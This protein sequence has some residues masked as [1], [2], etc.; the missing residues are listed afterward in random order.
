MERK[1]KQLN[2][3]ITKGTNYTKKNSKSNSYS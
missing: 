1:R 2:T 3:N